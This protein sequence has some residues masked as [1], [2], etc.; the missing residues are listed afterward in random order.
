M[1]TALFGR[2]QIVIILEQIMKLCYNVDTESTELLEG[3]FEDHSPRFVLLLFYYY[4]YY[5]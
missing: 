2:Y 4:Y 1:K 5:Y 3:K